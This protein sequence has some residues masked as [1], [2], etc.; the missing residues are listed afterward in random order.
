MQPATDLDDDDDLDD[1]LGLLRSGRADVGV[2]DAADGADEDEALNPPG[3]PSVMDLV[4]EQYDGDHGPAGVGRPEDRSARGTASR[5]GDPRRAQPAPSLVG[6]VIALSI[7]K[8]SKSPTG[9]TL[10]PFPK[11]EVED[12][13]ALGAAL[14]GVGGPLHSLMDG[15]PMGK[16]QVDAGRAIA[17]GLVGGAD[18]SSI[19][20]ALLAQLTGAAW[21]TYS[22]AATAA[23]RFL[24]QTDSPAAGSRAA[25]DAS[26]TMAITS[27]TFLRLLEA[28]EVA[29]TRARE[30]SSVPRYVVR[31]VPREEGEDGR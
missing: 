12:R 17:Y 10:T 5:S 23:T 22:R 25:L 24:Q 2:P 20:V 6:E 4:G 26:R 16:L 13:R 15:T 3:V 28:I 9:W 29:K 27:R 1:G 8:D 19:E 18:P 30:R 11:D 31:R 7:R 21:V 14:E